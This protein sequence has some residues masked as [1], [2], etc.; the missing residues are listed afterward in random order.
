MKDGL[1]EIVGKTISSV[2]VANN[3][4]EPYIQVFLMFTDDT[5]F[6]FYGSNFSCCG[7]VDQG[8]QARALSYIENA[9]ASVVAVYPE[10]R[11]S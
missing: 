2:I 8:G 11:R 5:Q 1:N 6:E 7:G 10:K 9:G 3:N 4:R